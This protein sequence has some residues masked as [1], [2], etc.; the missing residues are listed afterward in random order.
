MKTF[1]PIASLL[2][3]GC[4]L[5]VSCGRQE[6]DPDDDNNSEYLILTY[7]VVGDTE[8][9]IVSKYTYPANQLEN[10]ILE[11][12]NAPASEF[13]SDAIIHDDFIY[14]IRQK[15]G[16]LDKVNLAD[17]TLAA[18]WQA[19]ENINT[20]EMVRYDKTIDIIDD[21]AVVAYRKALPEGQF[22]DHFFAAYLK[23]FNADNLIPTDSVFVAF[24]FNI[25]DFKEVE[26]KIFISLE[27]PG[28]GFESKIIVIDAATKEYITE[29]Q[30]E[31]STS[32]FL[33]TANNE[34]LGL[35][36]R[37][38]FKID[39]ISFTITE[40]AILDAGTNFE[41]SSPTAALDSENNLL[42]YYS[43]TAQPA[44]TPYRLASINLSTLEINYLTGH[45][46]ILSNQSP[47]AFDSKHELIIIGTVFNSV[48]GAG[49]KLLMLDNKGNLVEE[50]ILPEHAWKI[51]VR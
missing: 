50:V 12:D 16:V 42:Y 8:N 34:L 39:P 20:N 30:P 24:D 37:S 41:S 47:I 33:V 22:N 7:N 5:I 21:R 13:F 46:V 36:L 26:D 43:P 45:E 44:P 2:I 40:L 32:Q 9:G 31:Y 38:L 18:R 19:S 3:I 29:L 51:L 4:S 15:A 17:N 48:D 35:S 11:I 23:F 10:N 28:G 27:R 25:I 14:L 6:I 49:K 1:H